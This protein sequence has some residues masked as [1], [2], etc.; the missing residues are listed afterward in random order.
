MSKQQWCF[1]HAD[2][3]HRYTPPLALC[4]LS[5]IPHDVKR[6]PK[7]LAIPSTTQDARTPRASVN[8]DVTNALHSVSIIRRRRPES[9]TSTSSITT[10]RNLQQPRKNTNQQTKSPP[11]PKVSPRS[12]ELQRRL[13][14][15]DDTDNNPTTKTPTTELLPQPLSILISLLRINEATAT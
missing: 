11:A 9:S 1:H 8:N 4:L 6:C 13:Y 5:I 12:I 3:E 2:T 7:S 14:D 15:T 10:T